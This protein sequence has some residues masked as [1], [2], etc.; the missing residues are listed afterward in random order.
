MPSSIKLFIRSPKYISSEQIFDNINATDVCKACH[1]TLKRGNTRYNIAIVTIEYWYKDTKDIRDNLN[2]GEAMYI[3]MQ[4]ND[5]VAYKYISKKS[6]TH[7]KPDEFGRDMPRSS[8]IQ[9]T[10]SGRKE[11][12]SSSIERSLSCKSDNTKAAE[13]FIVEYNASNTNGKSY[14]M[15]HPDKNLK[16]FENREKEE[17]E[18]YL[19]CL[20]SHCDPRHG[21]THDE[22][23]YENIDVLSDVSNDSLLK[24]TPE[25]IDK[26]SKLLEKREK[27]ERE[28]Y[29]YC[30]QSHCP[31]TD[32]FQYISD[33]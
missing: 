1:V 4:G 24:N 26:R 7:T 11:N 19:Y 14:S 16:Y 13:K 23:Y 30:L 33:N 3:P 8:T 29:L 6:R 12:E 32:Y 25:N 28:N 20:Q 21:E 18:N 15:F 10:E 22:S 5:L 17:R 27:E 9:A 31:E 2:R